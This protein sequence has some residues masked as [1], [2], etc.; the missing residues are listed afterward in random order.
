MAMKTYCLYVFT[1]EGCEPCEKLKQHVATLPEPQQKE[2][3]FVPF[4]QKLEHQPYARG[5]RTDL[6]E[7]FEVTL[8]PTLLV[9]HE[10][11]SCNLD[12]EGEEW[13]DG[14]EVSVERFVGAT[15][16]IEHLPATLSA[17]TYSVNDD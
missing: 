15:S 11:V 17:Y 6:A 9:V 5:L 3:H 16:I 12:N 7:Q 14:I 13:C 1:Q 10:E 8:T 2:L 4:Y